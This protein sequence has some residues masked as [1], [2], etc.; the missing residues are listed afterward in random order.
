MESLNSSLAYPLSQ[1]DPHV[2]SKNNDALRF[3]HLKPFLRLFAKSVNDLTLVDPASDNS[4]GALL[5]SQPRAELG[6]PIVEDIFGKAEK[7][8]IC[9]I[10]PICSILSPQEADELCESEREKCIAIQGQSNVALPVECRAS[11]RPH[12]VVTVPASVNGGLRDAKID[13]ELVSGDTVKMCI[14]SS[15]GTR[16][17]ITSGKLPDILLKKLFDNT[18]AP[19]LAVEPIRANVLTRNAQLAIASFLERKLR[20]QVLCTA[21]MPAP[22]SRPVV[23]E[24]VRLMPFSRASSSWASVRA[25]LHQSSASCICGA[26]GLRIGGVNRVEAIIETCGRDLE[27]TPSGQYRC[28]CHKQQVDENGN[29]RNNQWLDNQGLC[30]EGTC[31]SVRCLHTNG[32]V[33]RAPGARIDRIPLN[34]AERL[35]LSSILMH[36]LEFEARTR[37]CFNAKGYATNQSKITF[38][39]TVLGEKLRQSLNDT[40]RQ[41]LAKEDYEETNPRAM[42]QRDMMAVD[43]MRGGGVFLH[44]KTRNGIRKREL[45]RVQRTEQTKPLSTNEEELVTTHG[46]LFRKAI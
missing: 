26:H 22:V 8:R 17:Y 46:H 14:V 20:L 21:T 32:G 40:E 2:D 27:K 19:E 35:E 24:S 39:A 41:Q 36:A 11:I 10:S 43:L 7:C 38:Q 18:S 23:L 28:P 31:I 9:L 42:L 4:F 1:I 33:T 12:V 13:I 6:R 29:S 44:T 34:D 30:T 15:S 25:V 3:T 45:K 5:S 16:K 37:D